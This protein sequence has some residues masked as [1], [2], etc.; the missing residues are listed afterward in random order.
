MMKR[1]ALSALTLVLATLAFAPTAT[2][3]QTSLQDLTADLNG[4]GMVTISELARYNR[5]Q[6][7]S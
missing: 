5:A 3:R 2:A 1:Y 7:Q 4:D 6:R